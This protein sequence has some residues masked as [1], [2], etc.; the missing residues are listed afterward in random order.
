VIEDTGVGAP[1]AHLG[2]IVLQR[3][4]RLAHFMFGGLLDLGDAGFSHFNSS[5]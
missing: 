1:G 3:F 4:Q 2:Q 5:T